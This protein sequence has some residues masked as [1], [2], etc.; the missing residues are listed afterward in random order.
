MP[1]CIP[2]KQNRNQPIQS[3]KRLY[4]MRHK[5]ENLLA[6][7]KDWRAALQHATTAVHLSWALS[8]SWPL[9]LSSGYES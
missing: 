6:N 2:P 5:V 9:P 4:K 1:P 3:S 7:L 8:S